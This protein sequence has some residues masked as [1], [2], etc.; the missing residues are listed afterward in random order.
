MTWSILL[1]AEAWFIGN[2]YQK[3]DCKYSM[4]QVVKVLSSS[5]LLCLSGELILHSA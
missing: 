1:E 5:I 2:Q 3:S 4:W